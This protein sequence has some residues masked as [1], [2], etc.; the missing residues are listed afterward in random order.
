M[1]IVTAVQAVTLVITIH[2][3]RG[4]AARRSTVMVLLK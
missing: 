1:V 2:E 3:T 4:V